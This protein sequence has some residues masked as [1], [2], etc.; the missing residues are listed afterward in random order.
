VDAVRRAVQA[1]V[2]RARNGE[3]PSL[4][5]A[6]TWR[7]RGHWAGDAQTYRNPDSEPVDVEDPLDLYAYRLLADGRA[8][9]EDLQGVH[10]TVED[11]VRA[12]MQQALAAPDPTED[13]LGLEDVYA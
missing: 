3:G 8:T 9:P 10:M 1:A 12:A 7:W 4:I 13:D 6:R 2:T 11:E 5:E